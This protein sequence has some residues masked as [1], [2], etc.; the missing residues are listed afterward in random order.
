MTLRLWLEP[1]TKKGKISGGSGS[2]NVSFCI[3]SVI[4]IAKYLCTNYVMSE[5]CFKIFQKK[6]C[7]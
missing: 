4:Y 6:K 7:G 3:K 5:N 2:F 1:F